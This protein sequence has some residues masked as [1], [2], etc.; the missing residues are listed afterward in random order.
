MRK[1]DSNVQVLK[2]KV[3]REVARHSWKDEE[4]FSVFDEIAQEIVKKGEPST[5]CCIYK[6]RAKVAER[7]RIA[8]GGNKRTLT[9]LK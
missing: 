7:I 8:L 2:Y 3:L 5:S 6:D 9:S 4:I 1:F